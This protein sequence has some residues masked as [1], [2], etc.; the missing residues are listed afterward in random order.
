MPA[1]EPPLTLVILGTGL[2]GTALGHLA[3]GRGHRVL[4]WSRHRGPSLEE[5]LPQA[6]V[7]IS[8]VAMAGV[9]PVAE[10][11]AAVGLPASTLLV[12]VTKGLEIAS[13]CTPSQIWGNRLPQHPL[14]VLSGP[15]L[16]QEI[17][18]GLP[19]ATVVASSTAEVAQAIQQCLASERF[20]IYTNPDPLGTELGGTLKNVMA[21]AAG[22]CD[23][24]GLGSNAKAALITRA[25]PEMVQVGVHLGG[26]PET[27]YGLSGLGDLLTT[28]YSVLSRN[29]RLGYGLG[30]GQGLEAVLSS[31]ATTV[32][33]VN[34]TKAVIR[35]GDRTGLP[36]PII[37]Q[38]HHLLQGEISAGEAVGR[39]MERHLKPE[40]TGF[41]P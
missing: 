41:D 20:R 26:R 5:L 3:A 6:Q 13:G 10:Q 40:F 11:V 22:V 29:Y 4:F 32:E 38:V 14:A 1:V 34:T 8:A 33:G 30:Q 37:R 27:F 16:S 12:S 28:C 31:L 17:E 7:V 21:I 18:A 24:L 35:I 25:L 39:L 23:G 15:N 9:T 36:M 19:A 2:W